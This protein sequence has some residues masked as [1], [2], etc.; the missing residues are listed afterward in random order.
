[1]TY[2]SLS[3]DLNLLTDLSESIPWDQIPAHIEKQIARKQHLEEEIQRLESVASE[4]KTRLDMALEQ[5]AVTMKVLNEYSYFR[6]ELNKNR[7]PMANIPA[8]VKTINGLHQRGYDANS[9]VSKFSNFEELQI[10]EKELKD[11][12]DFL[13]KR[14]DKLECDCKYFELQIDV[15]SQTLAKYRELEDIGFGLKEQKLLWHK[16]REI[17]V[18]N[19]MS[20]KEAVQ[21]FLKDVEEEYDTKLGFEPKIQKSKSELQNKA[22]MMQNMSSRMDTQIQNNGSVK[23]FIS[24][25]LEKQIE[26]LTR[27]S[28]FSSLTQAAKGEMVAP[29]ELKFSL[30]KAIETVLVRLDPNDSIVKVLE[31]TKLEL[32]KTGEPSGSMSASG[33]DIWG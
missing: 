24:S 17:G 18:A 2:L 1:L 9:I 14:K 23:Q 22:L 27:I 8:V 10:V 30:R 3:H 13:T 20:P 19:Q 32:E 11:S 28:E 4:A 16:V 25:I 33:S 5:E 6:T 29:N 15:H 26:Q 31:T 7:I 21:K 12:V